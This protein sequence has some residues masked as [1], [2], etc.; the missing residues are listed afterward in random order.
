MIHP[1]AIIHLDAELADDVSVG[2][3]S[4]INSGVKIGIG[5]EIAS[6]VLIDVGTV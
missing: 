1:S 3:Y 2:P 6:H 5:T 4:I